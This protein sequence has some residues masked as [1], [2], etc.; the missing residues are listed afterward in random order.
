MSPSRLASNDEKKKL[1]AQEG[2]LK[3]NPLPQHD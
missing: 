1:V 3:K 2:G